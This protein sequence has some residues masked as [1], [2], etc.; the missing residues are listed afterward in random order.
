MMV[1]WFLFF[2]G[3]AIQA[4]LQ[5]PSDIPE[6]VRLMVGR[7]QKNI[8]DRGDVPMFRLCVFDHLSCRTPSI[9]W[10]SNLTLFLL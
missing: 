2:L 8:E 5:A 4:P 6:N 7:T 1:G 10:F 9:F 3:R